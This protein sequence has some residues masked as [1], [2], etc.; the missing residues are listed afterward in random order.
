MNFTFKQIV[1]IFF[2]LFASNSFILA[3]IELSGALRNDALIMINTNNSLFSDVIENKLVFARNT[4]DWRYYADLRVYLYFGGATNQSAGTGGI[5]TNIAVPY[6]IDLMRMFIRYHSGVGDFTAGKTYV[7]FG[8][9]GVFNPFEMSKQVNLQDLNYD[10]D[11]ILALTHNFSFSG[12]SGGSWYVAPQMYLT[13]SGLGG[14]LFFNQ[15][16]FDFGFVANRK[17]Y[18]QN[19]TGAYLKGDLEVGVN[20][21]YAYHFDDFLTNRFSKA[22]A[23]IDYS[24]FDG[25]LIPSLTFYYDEKGAEK[26][27]DYN[28]LA[29]DD[30]YFLAKY[31]IYGNITY[32]YD[33]FLSFQFNMFLNAIDGSAILM[34]Q[35][36]Y[37][38][39]DGLDL[40]GLFIWFT[41]T[42]EQEFSPDR[43]NFGQYAVDFRLEGKL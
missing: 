38:L 24:F 13:N 35:V 12:L 20:A 19:L 15:S 41:G 27:N 40:T 11:G 16:K 4:E 9:L 3:N 6:S 25:K 30:K 8:I 31:Y 18:D 33:E 23:G 22:S 7:N 14:S 42:G 37:T 29:T 2:C 32:I 5:Q 28:P 36:K 10:K 21:S 43:Y 34:P 1:F 39:S 17:A 26:T